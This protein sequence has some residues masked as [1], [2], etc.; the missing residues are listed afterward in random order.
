[1]LNQFKVLI[2]VALVV[3]IAAA[4]GFVYVVFINP[5]HTESLGHTVVVAAIR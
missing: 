1:V 2:I 3:A 5:S 4:V